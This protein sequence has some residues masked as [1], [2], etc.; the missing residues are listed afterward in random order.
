[1]AYHLHRKFLVLIGKEFSIKNDVGQTVAYARQKAF[2]LRE[3]IIVYENES[4]SDAL[5]SIKARNIIDFNGTYDIIEHGSG[6]IIASLQRQ[7]F[8]SMLR[9]EWKVFNS[10]GAE[11]GIIQEESMG[12]ALIRRFLLNLIPQKFDFRIG[13]EDVGGFQQEF[14]LFFYNLAIE[15]KED[16]IDRR[17][18]FAAAILLGAIE[19]KQE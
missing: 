2:K 11:I 4:M 16:V 15:V 14:N 13:T 5:F 6:Q 1:M 17:V 18:A 19:G 10:S 12:L 8:A 9:D 7:G 3:E